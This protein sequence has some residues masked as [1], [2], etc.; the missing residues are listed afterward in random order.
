MKRVRSRRDIFFFVLSGLA[1]SLILFLLFLTTMALTKTSQEDL[2]NILTQFY[3]TL[4]T[5][6]SLDMQIQM[7]I[8]DALEF[9]LTDYKHQI[10]ESFFTLD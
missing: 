7:G 5:R 9:S 2:E 3:Q 4:F 10:C 8:I 1:L 6:D